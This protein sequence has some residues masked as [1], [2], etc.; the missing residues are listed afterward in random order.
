MELD[1]WPPHFRPH[2]HKQTQNVKRLHVSALSSWTSPVVKWKW[3]FLFVS[4][5]FYSHLFLSPHIPLELT[6]QVSASV[7]H[8]APF[9][10]PLCFWGC[11]YSSQTRTN[12][13]GIGRRRGEEKKANCYFLLS[14]PMRSFICLLF[15]FIHRL[16]FLSAY[17]LC[18]FWVIMIANVGADIIK[19]RPN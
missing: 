18:C 9:V 4:A 7:T 1:P 3:F 13:R 8:T 10:S 6:G 15:H 12:I 17:E 2:G 19:M 5:C 16:L 11:F 14:I